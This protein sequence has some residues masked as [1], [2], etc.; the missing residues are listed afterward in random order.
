[1]SWWLGFSCQQVW[2]WI[3]MKSLYSWNPRP[4]HQSLFTLGL[5]FLTCKV[6]IVILLFVSVC[7]CSRSTDLL[8]T[9]ALLTTSTAS[10]FIF[11]FV[12]SSCKTAVVFPDI[13]LIHSRKRGWKWEVIAGQKKEKVHRAKAHV[14]GLYLPFLQKGKTFTKAPRWFLLVFHWP[15]QGYKAPPSVRE[16]GRFVFS[17]CGSG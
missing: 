4:L 3:L 10:F 8:G 15:E 14:S 2:F 9:K 11:I 17:F 7:I 12:A 16:V 6:G 13:V 1:M 5:S